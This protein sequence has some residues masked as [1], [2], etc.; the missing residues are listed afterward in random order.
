MDL[1]TKATN[2]EFFRAVPIFHMYNAGT[3]AAKQSVVCRSTAVKF[4]RLHSSLTLQVCKEIFRDGEILTH[5]IASGTRPPK[6]L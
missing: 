3:A 1:L 6:I 2:R 5:A 4:L